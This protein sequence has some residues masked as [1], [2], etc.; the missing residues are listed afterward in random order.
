[1]DRRGGSTARRWGAALTAS[2]AA[3]AVVLPSAAEAADGPAGIGARGAYLLDGRSGRALWGKD[4]D[5]A[6]PI[7]STTKIMTAVVALG[8]RRSDLNKQVTIKQSYRDYVTRHGASTADLRTG[9]RLTVRQLL[10]AL[11]LPSGC[12]AAYALADALGS[13][14]SEAERTKSFV[15]RMNREAARLGMR[16]THFDSFDGITTGGNHSTPRDLAKLAR[17]ALGDST[18]VTVTKAMSTQQ[19]AQNV[20]RRYT[21]YN[22]NKLLGSYEG[23]LGV[24]TGT[25]SASGPCLVF[26]ARRGGRT[27]VGVLLNDAPNRY[28]DAARMLDYAYHTHTRFTARK[29]PAAAH[30]D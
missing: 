3:L 11:M 30:D 15:A 2:A 23:V 21:W 7:A 24:K 25:T 27:V 17:H 29:L 16:R 28:P 18:L 12:D 20:N 10:Y 26:A 6:R 4:A 19:K 22:T 9:D 13:G 1:M 5:T 14:G 8:G